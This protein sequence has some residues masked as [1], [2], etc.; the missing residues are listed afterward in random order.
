[1]NLKKK[2]GFTIAELVIVIA[3]IAVLAA[4][5]IPTFASLV[6]SA[7]QPADA[8]AVS[9][10]NQVLAKHAD[11]SVNTVSDVINVL[12][13]EKIDLDDYKPLKKNHYFYFYVQNGT[14]K[15]VYMDKD[16][17][18]VY[19]KDAK[20]DGEQLMS[21]TG[22]VPTDE[23]YTVS[24]TGEVTIDS[25]AKLAHLLETKRGRYNA[26]PSS[27]NLHITLSGKIDLRGAAV[28]FGSTSGEI[29]L[30]GEND[31]VLS[32]LCAN[33][34]TVT[35]A[36]EFV[37]TKHGYGLFGN[38][39][40]GTV[41]IENLTIS[42]LTA[43]DPNEINCGKTLGLVAG[44][45]GEGAT[46]NLNN[47][48][49]QDCAV[50]GFRTVGGV[51][52]Q[53]CGTLNMDN[54]KFENV[55]VNGTVEVAKVI[56]TSSVTANLTVTDCDFSGITVK[57]LPNEVS[58][59]F[60]R[61]DVEYVL[62]GDLANRYGYWAELHAED[63]Q[64]LIFALVTNDLTWYETAGVNDVTIKSALYSLSSWVNS[65]SNN[66]VDGAPQA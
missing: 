54:V 42:R 62:K 25:G 20:I 29:T 52:G 59:V 13:K 9:Q 10:M 17:N 40:G 2:K 45:V 61:G 57:H 1:M 7:N 36:D 38:I 49:F 26:N 55:S 44:Y 21:L 60:L 56:G 15:I 19:P 18:V 28:D 14:P 47:V 64:P 33:Q 58:E 50:N 3:V 5:L 12:K 63:E 11:G 34:N 16:D 39:A 37:G 23:H 43:S 65:T 32:G 41:T 24:E 22:T 48:T 8:H 30:S 66:L 35:V 6:N 46:V 4:V 53:L 51:V 31:A 27:E